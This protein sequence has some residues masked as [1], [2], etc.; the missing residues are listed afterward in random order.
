MILTNEE[1]HFYAHLLPIALAAREKGY[2]VMVVCPFAYP[3]ERL[4]SL[5]FHTVPLPLDRKSLNP[6]KELLLLY[7]LIK[8]IA[9]N[10]PDILHNFTSKPILY[11]SLVGTFLNIPIIVN[12]YLGMGTL[13]ISNKVSYKILR[14]FIGKTLDALSSR[15]K[16]IFVTQNKEDRE[17]LLRLKVAPPESILT[18]CIVGVDL[19]HYKKL[20]LPKGKV[21]FALIGRMLKDK[22]VF[23]FV[24]A[25]K[26]LKQRGYNVGC[27]LVGS[28]DP[29]NRTSL[30]ERTLKTWHQQG[31]ITY[32]GYQQDMVGLL[33]KIHVSVLPSY[34]E[35][36]SRSLLEAAACGRGIITTDAP[37][38]SDLI[39]DGRDGLLVPAREPL[40]LADAMERLLQN[41]E[42]LKIFSEKA[43]ALVSS[44]Y[45]MKTLAHRMVDLY[46]FSHP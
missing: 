30:D 16:M 24:A 17:V 26:I 18:Q 38:G 11:G 29:G 46:K 40:A 8:I 23:E 34:R 28:P 7:R 33:K 21:I 3:P 5:D 35:G 6:F 27:W 14:Q 22:G 44:T 9:Q 25:S 10:R 12:T 45:E 36:L 32:L 31:D 1:G 4:K 42:E 2:A 20:P 15:K 37:G 19:D 43:H 41:P 13:F 39:T